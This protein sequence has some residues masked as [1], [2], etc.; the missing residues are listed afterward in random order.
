MLYANIESNIT[1][2]MFMLHIITV[3]NLLSHTD[4]MKWVGVLILE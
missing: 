3:Y 1:L 4:T 2:L